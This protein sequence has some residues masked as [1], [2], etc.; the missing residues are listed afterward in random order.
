MQFGKHIGKGIWAFDDKALPAIYALGFIFLVVRTLP[1]QEY[2]SFAI[3][4]SIFL[5]VSS[6]GYAL[7]LQPL[8]K[9]AAETDD[10]GAYIVA[11]LV[12][13]RKSVV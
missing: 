5:I 8:T 2:G 7:A 1:E 3:I 10:N 4:Q 12:V 11:S 6:L 13:D 9:F